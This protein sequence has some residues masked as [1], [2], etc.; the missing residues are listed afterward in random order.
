MRRLP[1]PAVADWA[2]EVQ[3]PEAP[4]NCF[5]TGR[6][7]K[8]NHLCGSSE[9]ETANGCPV[10]QMQEPPPRG[11]NCVQAILIRSNAR[12]PERA[13]ETRA[14]L[15]TLTYMDVGNTDITTIWITSG[16]AATHPGRGKWRI[17]GR[18]R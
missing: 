9:S 11:T 12:S 6:E 1:G 14:F 10:L 2:K 5:G 13:Q 3:T 17:V 4:T 15:L 7:H 8:L 18:G 16:L